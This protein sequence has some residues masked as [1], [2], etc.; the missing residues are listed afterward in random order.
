MKKFGKRLV[1]AMLAGALLSG[2][3]LQASAFSFPS[4]YW[5]LQDAWLQA[6]EAQDISRTITVAQQTYDLF[7]SYPLG[8]EVCEVMEPRCALAAWCYGHRAA[9]GGSAAL[10]R[11]LHHEVSDR[12][13]HSRHF[14]CL[15]FSLVVSSVH[16]VPVG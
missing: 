8:Q 12:F 6:R 15:P 13:F 11:P 1:T 3:C 2:F 5:P 7:K 9:G 4:S 10:H 16:A 14:L